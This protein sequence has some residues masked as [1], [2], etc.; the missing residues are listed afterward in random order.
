METEIIKKT[1][2]VQLVTSL[3]RSLTSS[4]A[5]SALLGSLLAGCGGGAES[6]P[7]AT[8]GAAEAPLRIVY[9]R[10][11]ATP[12]GGTQTDLY[13]VSE[14]GTGEVALATS[15]DTETL[16]AGTDHVATRVGDRV[17][18]RRGLVGSR[19][20]YS[21]RIDG[22]DTA[23][24]AASSGD[25]QVLAVIG[26]RVLITDERSDLLTIRADGRSP[27]ILAENARFVAAQQGRIFYDRPV[28][29]GKVHLF[30][31]QPDGAGLADLAPSSG[32][33]L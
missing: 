6:I 19:D 29:V 24:L 30:S 22:T 11:V 12:G 31:V 10:S 13:V 26:D 8:G 9:Q 17:L 5:I 28:S 7:P 16:I 33:A 2:D 3:A 18:Y 1:N 14:D 20:V 4:L 27:V 15:K 25:K 32:Q 21:V 23:V